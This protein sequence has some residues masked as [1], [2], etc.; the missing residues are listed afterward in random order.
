MR[1]NLLDKTFKLKDII[2]NTNFED[3]GVIVGVSVMVG[4]SATVVIWVTAGDAVT[5]C[6][7]K[8]KTT[9]SGSA[10][11]VA[12]STGVGSCTSRGLSTAV[13]VP[14]RTQ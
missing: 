4:V 10:S 12:V 2:Q 3:H 13:P 11:I 9:P 14:V 5:Y 8:S 6:T 1:F 7:A